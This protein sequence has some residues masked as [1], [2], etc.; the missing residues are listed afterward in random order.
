MENFVQLIHG[1][2]VGPRQRAKNRRPV[3]HLDKAIPMQILR[4]DHDKNIHIYIYPLSII[5]PLYIIIYPLSPLYPQIS[6]G[7]ISHCHHQNLGLVVAE[8]PRDDGEHV[9]R[10][11]QRIHHNSEPTLGRAWDVKG[12]LGLAQ[13]QLT[14]QMWK[15]K[16]LSCSDNFGG[17]KCGGMMPDGTP[18]LKDIT[19]TALV[20]PVF[21]HLMMLIALEN[22]I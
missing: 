14:S 22:P 2:L 7:T 17:F 20:Q 1:Q 15:Q 8:V 9:Q 13:G 12:Y 21:L 6:I 18:I 16:M 3:D 5:G 4:W 19:R 11:W 10:H